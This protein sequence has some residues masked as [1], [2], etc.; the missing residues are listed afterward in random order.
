[1]YKIHL[2]FDEFGELNLWLLFSWVL[3]ITE[4]STY[5]LNIFL[6][7][8]VNAAIFLSVYREA[9]YSYFCS[10]FYGFLVFGNTFTTFC[11]V[12]Q[13]SLVFERILQCMNNFLLMNSFLFNRFFLNS[14][15]PYC[16]RIQYQRQFFTFPFPRS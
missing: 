7:L 10:Y 12:Y 13:N 5:F 11:I 8:W 16:C 4:K 2:N 1:M 3:T 15:L 6:R 14:P 9:I